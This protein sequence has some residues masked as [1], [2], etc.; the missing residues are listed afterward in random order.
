MNA[1][2][3]FHETLSFGTPDRPPL[4]EEGLREDVL[5]SWKEQGMP[6]DVELTDLFEMDKRV[7]IP[8]SLDPIPPLKDWH[9]TQEGL[10]QY[11]RAFDPHD[12]RRWPKDWSEKVKAWKDS[13]TILELSVHRGLFRTLNV[14][15]WSDFIEVIF[16]MKDTPGI[17]KKILDV[18]LEFSLAMIDQMLSEVSVDYLLF[19]EPIGGNDRPLISDAMYREF[20]LPRYRHMIESAKAWNAEWF[21]WM[22]FGNGR[23]LLPDLVDTGFNVLWACE[24][25]T[26]D[27][28]YLS[29]RNEF[30]EDLRLIGGIDLDALR[31]SHEEIRKE[32]TARVPPLL[33][34]GGYLPVA[35]GRVRTN[36]S[37]THYSFYRELLQSIV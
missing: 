1:R 36:M 23:V 11:K 29:I 2:K 8:I 24:T 16:A 31:G 20:L 33:E 18:A 19:S 32:V 22:T 26:P 35:D 5:A 10:A 37:W 17:V 7:R 34:S 25:E 15:N 12:T 28:D 13:G 6:Q 30:G 3:R 4:L 27:M 9:P 14:D 21:C